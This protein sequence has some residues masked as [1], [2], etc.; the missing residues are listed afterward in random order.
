MRVRVPPPTTHTH[1]HTEGRGGGAAARSLSGHGVL[2][3]MSASFDMVQ[4]YMKISV[5]YQQ[6]AGVRKYNNVGS[7]G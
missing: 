6:T 5:C 2:G 1:T 7:T 3:N 4:P